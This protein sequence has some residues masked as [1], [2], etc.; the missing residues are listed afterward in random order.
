MN[1]GAVLI[2]GWAWYDFAITVYIIIGFLIE[3]ALIEREPRPPR[4]YDL[5]WSFCDK[6]VAL[7]VL[8]LYSLSLTPPPVTAITWPGRLVRLWIIFAITWELAA[9]IS[10]KRRGWHL[11]GSRSTK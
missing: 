3:A 4:W 1:G 5:G 7:A 8:F 10:A 9:L 2:F 11:L 6:K